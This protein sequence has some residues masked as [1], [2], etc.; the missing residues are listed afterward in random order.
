[1]ALFP[2]QEIVKQFGDD[3]VPHG[4]AFVFCQV[5]VELWFRDHAPDEKGICIVDPVSKKHVNT[6]LENFQKMMRKGTLIPEINFKL[7]HIIESTSFVDSHKSIGVQLSDACNLFIKRHES[8]ALNND[9]ERFYAM[10]APHIANIESHIFPLPTSVDKV[11][12]TGGR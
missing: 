5:Q 8:G 10:L 6:L 1:M 7:T 12:K 4:M 3:R 11:L 9:A 2:D